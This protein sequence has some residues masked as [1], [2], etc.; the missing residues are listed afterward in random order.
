MRL[1]RRDQQAPC[2]RAGTGPKAGDWPTGDTTRATTTHALTRI[3]ATL[4]RDRWEPHIGRGGTRGW[5]A[6]RG[7]GGAGRRGAARR[8]VVHPAWAV[9]VLAGRVN[10]VRGK[11]IS[12]SGTYLSRCS[13]LSRRGVLDLDEWRRLDRAAPVSWGSARFR[14]PDG[15]AGG[16]LRC[17]IRPRPT[18]PYCSAIY[19]FREA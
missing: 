5:V 9:V 6:G 2:D 14:L 15:V 1:A 13:R 4:Q 18:P 12:P 8:R 16:R 11:H 7:G 17:S 10:H 3:A 19:A